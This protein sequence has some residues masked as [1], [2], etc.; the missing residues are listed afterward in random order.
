M[1]CS[2]RIEVV[3]DVA[4][5]VESRPQAARRGAFGI[6]VQHLADFVGGRIVLLLRPHERRVGLVVP[7]GVAEVEFR[8]MFGWCMWQ[9]MHCEVGIARVKACPIGCPLFS[10]RAP[11]LSCRASDLVGDGR[12]DRGALPVAAVLGV[13]E[14]MPRLAVV[15]VDD[16]AAGAA[17]L[18]IVAR[19]VVGAHEPHEGIVQPRLVDVEHR[20]GDA[21]AG[22][23]AAVGL[24]DVGP[25]RFLQPLDLAGGVGQADLRELR[26]DVRPPRSNTRK[27]SAGGTT[28]QVGSG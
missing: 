24:A 5:E 4:Q 21:Q 19:L 16:M 15:G 7:H 10:A 12:I 1:S 26:A 25:A 13:G 8:K 28:C 14:A 6:A 17:R 22:A 18:A 23:G 2:L 11:G 9:L 3:I 27:T 20:D